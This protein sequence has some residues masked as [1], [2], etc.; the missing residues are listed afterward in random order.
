MHEVLE[1]VVVDLQALDGQFPLKGVGVE[2]ADLVVIDIQLL[3]LL[4]VLQA[5]DLDYLVAGSLEDLQ[6]RELAEVKPVE[7][8]E[9]VVGEVEDF[10]VLGKEWST[11]EPLRPLKTVMSELKC[12]VSIL[13]ACRIRILS[14]GRLPSILTELNWLPVR[15]SSANLG[16]LLCENMP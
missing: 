15:S 5:V 2:L 13:L 8:L 7:V 11:C 4:K 10:E 6:L 16:N 12:S 9:Q 14:V 3:Q 1:S